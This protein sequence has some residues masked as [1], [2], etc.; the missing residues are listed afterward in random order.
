MMKRNRSTR[1]VT[2]I[3]GLVSSL[4]FLTG[5][6]GVLQGLFI[7]S[8]QNSIA[9][10]QTRASI[11]A[12]ELVATLEQ[13]G[14]ARLLA[15]GGPFAATACGAAG[16]LP[17]TPQLFLGELSPTPALLTGQ[18]F[19]GCFVDFDT[20]LLTAPAWAATMTPGYSTFDNAVFDRVIAVYSH[21]T[22]PEIM[23]VGVNVGWRDAGRV[24]TIK[25]FTAL[26][27]TATNQTNL[28]F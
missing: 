26:Y 23:Y 17:A 21:P 24:R 5:L 25:R 22:N 7:A 2:L 8:Q 19:T 4:I 14:R 10:R 27:D 20:Y 11:I 18:G 28:E 12:Q 16:S 15:A 13:Q 6:V 1:G 3:E 9:N